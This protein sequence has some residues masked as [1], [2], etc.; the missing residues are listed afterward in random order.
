MGNILTGCIQQFVS[1]LCLHN[2]KAFVWKDKCHDTK[3]LKST[4]LQRRY[5]LGTEIPPCAAEG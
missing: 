1:A 5:L 2:S 3:E 4:M